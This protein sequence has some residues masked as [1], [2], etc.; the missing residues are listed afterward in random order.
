VALALEILSHLF[1]DASKLLKLMRIGWGV[2]GVGI[3]VCSISEACA[4]SFRN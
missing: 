4:S 1:A 3:A 2:C